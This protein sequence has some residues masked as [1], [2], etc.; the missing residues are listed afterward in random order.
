MYN[1]SL[2]KSIHSFI[3]CMQSM[4]MQSF[5][6]L[7]IPPFIYP[8]IH[9]YIHPSIHPVIH[10]PIHSSIHLSII[11]QVWHILKNTHTYIEI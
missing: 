3:I 6:H 4:V 7:S 10:V 9:P 8:S 11:I 5:I 2:C 1:S